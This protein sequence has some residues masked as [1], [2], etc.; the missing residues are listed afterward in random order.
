[1]THHPSPIA[2]PPFGAIFD[3][4]GV[5]I[6]SAD[7]HRE[8]W[9]RYCAESGRK[10]NDTFF[11]RGFGMKNEVIIPELLNWSHDPAEIR[12][13]ADRKEEHYRDI[14]REKGAAPIPG[15]LP[16]LEKLR[17]AKIPCVIA[18]STVLENITVAL[19]VLGVGKYFSAII[20]SRD[21]SR[22]KP[23]PEVFLKAAAKT[24]MSPS[25]CIV[26]EDAHVG[27]EAARAAKIKVI[28]VTTTHPAHTLAD[29]DRVVSRLDELE[30]SAV[31]ELLG[32]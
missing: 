19:D 23:D 17:H 6:D 16:W 15:V 20:S 27:I 11:K 9:E 12:K 31:E 7:Y 2:N 30:I 8:S 4:D 28:A 10:L 32:V 14:L 22:G 1:M 26:F 25:R 5:V 13:I 29:A 3:W 21:V 24:G 18:S